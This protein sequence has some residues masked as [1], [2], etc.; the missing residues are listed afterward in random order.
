MVKKFCTGGAE[1]GFS[2]A[3]LAQKRANHPNRFALR[4]GFRRA[5]TFASHSN[6]RRGGALETE[7]CLQEIVDR[8]RA[9][10]AAGRLH[11]LSDEPADRFRIALRLRDLVLVL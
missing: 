1:S 8:L 7:L 6:E 2:T 5:E 9:R 3:A 10:F 4:D 11:H